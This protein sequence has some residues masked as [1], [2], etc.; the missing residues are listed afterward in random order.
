ML[1]VLFLLL[2]LFFI[3]TFV[4]VVTVGVVTVGV[5]TVGVV[6]VGVV[7]V[8]L[9]PLFRIMRNLKTHRFFELLRA[10][11]WLSRATGGQNGF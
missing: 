4:G 9:N 3:Q 2:L 6:T 10:A 1:L 5:V 8:A 11:C 7:T